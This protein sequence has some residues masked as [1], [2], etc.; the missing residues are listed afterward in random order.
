M[1]TILGRSDGSHCTSPV[2][3]PARAG[4]DAFLVAAQLTVAFADLELGA[5]VAQWAHQLEVGPDPGD[6]LRESCS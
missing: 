5:D 2:P 4:A 6:D 1:H 3:A